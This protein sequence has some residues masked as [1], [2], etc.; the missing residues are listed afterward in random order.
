MNDYKK[1]LL[2]NFVIAVLLVIYL[3]IYYRDFWHYMN[4]GVPILFL[5]GIIFLLFSGILFLIGFSVCSLT[6]A[7]N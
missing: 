5:G 2:V 7:V 3:V 4:I 1:P 6:L